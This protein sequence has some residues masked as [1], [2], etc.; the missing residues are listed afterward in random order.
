[1]KKREKYR[2]FFNLSLELLGLI[3][4]SFINRKKMNVCVSGHIGRATSQFFF[5]IPAKH[6]SGHPEEAD[7]IFRSSWVI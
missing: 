5:K 4:V 6:L 1:M 3:V 2:E 7:I